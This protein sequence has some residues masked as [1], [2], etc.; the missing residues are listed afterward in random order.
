MCGM[1]MTIWGEGKGDERALT[2]SCACYQPQRQAAQ[3]QLLSHKPL[4]TQRER[5]RERER[6]REGGRERERERERVIEEATLPQ[7]TPQNSPVFLLRMTIPS[8]NTPSAW[9]RLWPAAVSAPPPEWRP[10]PQSPGGSDPAPPLHTATSST[11]H[12]PSRLHVSPTHPM[13]CRAEPLSRNGVLRRE[14][15]TREEGASGM[16]PD[17]DMLQG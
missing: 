9:L 5:E 8:S 17:W 10:R 13:H 6:G 11:Y 3:M 15:E 2:P 7:V 12:A 4:A 1:Y 16:T 14:R